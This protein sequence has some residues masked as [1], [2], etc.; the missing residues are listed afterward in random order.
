MCDTLDSFNKRYALIRNHNKLF[1]ISFASNNI[2]EIKREIYIRFN[3]MHLKSSSLVCRLTAH[4][5]E[6]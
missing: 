2:V 4:N 1:N 5:F 3:E 6:V